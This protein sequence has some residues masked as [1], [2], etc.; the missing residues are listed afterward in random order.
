MVEMNPN[1]EKLMEQHVI[2]ALLV[3]IALLS[4]YALF[5]R[6]RNRTAEALNTNTDE[7][8]ALLKLDQSKQTDYGVADRVAITNEIGNEN[9]ETDDETDAQLADDINKHS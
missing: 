1:K 6:S 2:D 5:E 3:L 8:N 7:K 4:A 9:K